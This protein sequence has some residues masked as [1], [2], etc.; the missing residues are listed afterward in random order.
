MIGAHTVFNFIIIRIN[1]SGL[2]VFGYSVEAFESELSEFECAVFGINQRISRIRIF[3]NFSD[4]IIAL[5]GINFQR[6]TA[7][8]LYVSFF[9]YK[10]INSL[11]E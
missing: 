10:E 5:Q 6:N 11:N 7:V 9:F 4:R 8:N 1:Q 3:S 2:C